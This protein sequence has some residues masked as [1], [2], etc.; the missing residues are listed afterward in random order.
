M[1][2]PTRIERNLPGILDDLSAGPT[3]DYL[4]DLFV[5]TGRMRQRPA[6]TF[7]ERWLPVSDITRPRVLTYAPPLRSIAVALVVIAL[8]LVAVLAF[9]GS[10]QHR[11]PE[12]FGPARNG[13]IPYDNGGDL[14]VG[15]PATGNSRIVL[16]GAGTDTAPGFSPDGTR[17]VFVRD[18]DTD[19]PSIFVVRPDGS[20]L[21]QVGSEPFT[22][23]GW[24][25]WAPDSRHL[26]VIDEVDGHKRLQSIDVTGQDAPVRLAN[27]PEPGGVFP[28]EPD[29]V[30]FRPPD[31]K[32]ILFRAKV[33]ESFGLFVM[34]AD[35]G[36]IQELLPPAD[37]GDLHLGSL[38]YSTDGNRIYYQ[39]AFTAEEA[40]L[41]PFPDNG[42][43]KLWVMNADGTR[44][45]AFTSSSSPSWDGM[46]EVSPD[47]RW[48][49][50]W[51]GHVAVTRA[52]GTGTIIEISP[53][54]PGNLAFVWSPDS[55]MILMV[56]GR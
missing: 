19:H 8:L 41:T 29:S 44:P 3:P 15:D 45:E 39:R 35:G 50:F 22:S 11:V 12:P 43:C 47:G 6:W 36:H 25:T 13:L 42:C 33:N 56:P 2:A 9:A 46:A 28:L 49:A 17:I 1:T 20:D 7:L 30:V 37:L 40:A 27:V 54:L 31:G 55:T 18:A 48:I 4:D 38:S 52:D 14:Y 53:E 21:R 10:Q 16:A 24:M 23:L 5:R 34:D 26:A 51:D 32:Q